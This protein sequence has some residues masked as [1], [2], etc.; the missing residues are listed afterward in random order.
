M[1]KWPSPVR[2]ELKGGGAK[3][4]MLVVCK[5]QVNDDDGS[6]GERRWGTWIGDGVKIKSRTHF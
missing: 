4:S 2:V 6:E 1:K 5:I 3:G